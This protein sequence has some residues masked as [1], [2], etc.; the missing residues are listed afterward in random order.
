MLFYVLSAEELAELLERLGYEYDQDLIRRNFEYYIRRTS[1]GSTL[2]RV[3]HA[4]VAA[5]RDRRASWE[6]FV[7]A[8]HSDVSHVRGGT[9]AE[10]I[11]LGAMVG[12]LDLVQRCYTGLETRQDMLRFN[13]VIPEELGKVAFDVRYRGHLVHLDFTTE[14][15]RASVDADDG[16]PITVDIKGV[17]RLVEPGETVEV[18]IRP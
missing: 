18:K 10:G 1:H 13:P 16:A 17:R 7:Q 11:H 2:S 3:V 14:V 6:L 15:A 4:W 9:T 12:T 5:R 8:L